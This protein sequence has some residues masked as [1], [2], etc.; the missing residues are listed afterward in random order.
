M[1]LSRLLYN[2][3][4]R[5][6]KPKQNRTKKQAFFKLSKTEAAPFVPKEIEP[7]LPVQSLVEFSEPSEIYEANIN[8]VP[9]NIE[10]IVQ[11][12]QDQINFK[13]IGA[14]AFIA[15]VIVFGFQSAKI[16]ASG[17]ST[18][19]KV[20]NS[21]SVALSQLQD[22]QA[23]VQQKDFLSAEQQFS[24]AQK[25]FS[26]AQKNISSLGLVVNSALKL[27][28]Q[29]KSADA[30]LKAGQSLS[31][32]GINL[33]NFFALI[34]QV[35]VS[36]AGFEAPDGFYG[37]VNAARKYLDASVVSLDDAKEKLSA[38]QPSDLPQ[39]YQADYQKYKDTLIVADEA[40]HQISS[41]LQLFQQFIG[42]NQKNILVL[43]QNN[44]ELRPTGGFI[45]T[46]GYFKLNNGKIDSQKI[47]S[48]YDLDGQIKEKI[49]APGAMHN[50]TPTWALRDSN[51]FVDFAASARKASNFYEKEAGETP[52][53][54][55]AVTPDLF[56]DLLKITGPIYFPKYNLTLTADNFRD[57][58]QLNTSVL[59]DKELNTPK[60][61]LADFA[62]LVLQKLSELPAGSHTPLLDALFQNIV[63]KNILF[64][65]RDPDI[66]QKFVE[67]NWAGLINDTDSDYLAIYN[68][69]LSG[70]KTDVDVIQ[71]AKLKSEVQRD[72]SI[73]NTLTYTRERQDLIG[74][75][76]ANVDYARFLV[77]EG[78]QLISAEGFQSRQ[79]YGLDT[80][81]KVDADLAAIEQTTSVDSDSGTVIS[82]ESN[83]TVFAN[84]I[85]VAPGQKVT[86][87]LKYRLPFKIGDSKHFSLLLQKQPGNNPIKLNYQLIQ[88]QP[89]AWYTPSTLNLNSNSVSYSADLLQDSFLG[90]VFDD[91][92]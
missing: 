73:V 56:I 76:A 88:K 87:T 33:N 81:F 77:P 24:Y 57:Q 35:K 3:D 42:Q 49:G 78:S 15:I 32:A 86:V 47:T 12:Q 39:A 90:I 50:V 67:Y 4:M 27:T 75:S 59:Y 41:L 53:A 82:T 37:T 5:E 14:F 43:F 30:L 44:N 9:E 23:L 58:I 70:T 65:D 85:E 69:N 13:G 80:S 25:N 72:G 54:V 21:T 11:K 60:Q 68:A 61:M 16:I 29:G 7:E 17:L 2:K 51:W 84:W 31:E 63:K 74:P 83:K 38:V 1:F 20:I 34:S 55:V 36:P 64:Y 22:A 40:A 89:I 71:S 66:Q 19:A 28:P 6:F 91:K 48:I 26:E 8:F 10:Q 92:K 79:H 18:K 46:Y 45:G 52:D 62:P